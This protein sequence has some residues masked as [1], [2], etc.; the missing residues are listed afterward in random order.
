M[1]AARAILLRDLRLG[2]RSGAGTAQALMFF[3]IL[4]LLI[5]LGIGPDTELLA[6]IAPGTLWLGALLACLLSLDRLFQ[7]DLEDGSL[8]VMALA[9]LP[10]ELVAAAKAAAHW[11]STGLPLTLASPLLALA[12]NLPVAAL[13][14]LMAALALGTP[15]LSAIGGIGAALTLGLRQGGLLIAILTLPLY[16]PTLIFGAETA[17][18]AADGRD[19]LPALALTT[20]LTLATIALAPFAT[21]AILRIQL[22]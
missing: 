16:I 21:A 7:A 19:P 13:P 4:I 20:A 22:R 14:W 3:L 6:R 2:L 11:L 17:I 8:D 12:L 18:A 9:P 5:P 1:S 10:L 15:A